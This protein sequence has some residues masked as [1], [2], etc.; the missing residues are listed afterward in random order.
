M[1][2][3]KKKPF[4]LYHLGM[5]LKFKL[6]GFSGLVM[7]NSG[8]DSQH[9]QGSLISEPALSNCSISTSLTQIMYFKPL[10]LMQEIVRQHKTK[11]FT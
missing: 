9:W 2:V 7:R 4:H 3:P 6:H 11:T 8:F 10:G 1:D 5:A